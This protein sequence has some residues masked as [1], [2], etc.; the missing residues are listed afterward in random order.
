MRAS[1]MVSVI[2]A[3]A[4]LVCAPAYGW[5]QP[6]AP[7]AA[8]QAA[9]SAQQKPVAV[10]DDPDLDFQPL[11]PDFTIVNLPTTLRLPRYK[12][13]FRISHRFTRPLGQGDFTDLLED[14]L[15]IDGPAQ[16]GLEYRFGLMRGTQVG[17]RRTNDR[18]IQFSSE[19]SLMEQRG[20]GLVG[21]GI[22]AMMEGTNNFSDSYSPILGAT[23]SRTF[24]RFGAGYLIPLWVNNS[25]P[26]PSEL[27]EDND[28][29]LLGVG[30]RLRV[31]R[32]VYFVFEVVP[33]VGGYAPNSTY[34]SFAVE[35]VVGGHAFQL[36]F[37]NSFGTMIRT[38][39][40]GAGSSSDWY[41]GFNI[42]RK[43]F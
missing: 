4:A 26:E 29:Y 17:V 1:R 22:L 16:I 25:N 24:G 23:I 21:I 34:K 3:S 43:F 7:D 20:G 37:S 18:T 14:F 8:A 41:M 27:V 2:A 32:T 13:G 10:P 31:L 39:A 15:S 36:N 35:K 9:S 6:A 5:S 33:R 19:Y 42:S 28:T 11:Q 38:L 40:E 12:Q 30:G